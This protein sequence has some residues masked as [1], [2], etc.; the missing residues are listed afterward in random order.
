MRKRMENFY[1]PLS[2]LSPRQ[3][4]ATCYLLC[5]RHAVGVSVSSSYGG[6]ETLRVSE[7]HRAYNGGNPRTAQPP[8]LPR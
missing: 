2:P 3:P 7:G 1:S 5:L 6:T 8:R 4:H